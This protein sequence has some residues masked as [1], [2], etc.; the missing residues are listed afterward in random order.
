MAKSLNTGDALYATLSHLFCVDDDNVIKEL[1]AGLACTP[2]ANVLLPGTGSSTSPVGRSFRTGG[3]AGTSPV[4]YGVDFPN[5]V[6]SNAANLSFFV[7]VN[8][9]N[10]ANNGGNPADGAPMF[11]ND[12]AGLRVGEGMQLDPATGKVFH[13]NING[14]AGLAGTLNTAGSITA[15]GVKSFGFTR[16]AAGV[17]KI[18][19]NGVVDS[20]YT[21]GVA[22][23]ASQFGAAWGTAEMSLIGGMANYG[24]VSFDYAYVCDWLGTILTDADVLRLHNSLA[25]GDAFDLITLPAPTSPTVTTQPANSSV[26]EGATATFTAAFANTPTS[27]AWEV[28]TDSGAT[29]G[30]V[31]GGSGATTTAY[32]T[33]ATTLAMSGRRFR[34]TAT[35]AGGSVTTNG[36]AT[37]TVTAAAS[38]APAITSQP[39]NQTA[40]A[41]G[42]ATFT[43]TATGSGALT[44]QW[45][46]NGVNV[47]VAV[48]ITASVPF[49]YTTPAL[50]TG[51][52]GALYSVVVTGD[53]G[54][55]ATSANATLTVNPAAATALN[56]TIAAAA[57]LTGIR[58]VVLN[59]A[60]PGVGATVIKAFAD[61]VFDGAGAMSIDITSL[62]VLQGQYRWVE[63]T[64][65]NGD[66]AQSPAP[67]GAHGPVVAS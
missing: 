19:I 66:P 50:V 14:R 16:T 54:P 25:G 4:V 63:L 32:T 3:G 27:W 44:A 29:W 60:M 58:G 48:S 9:Y 57:G 2:H 39:G 10:S 36:A 62:G 52:S 51:D 18:Y 41:G 6:A 59:A 13:N 40:T 33:A 42:T 35:N 37:L 55:P 46:K 64:Q 31:S 15:G 53:T 23:T 30:A 28:S 56:L 61:E 1:K 34:C 17:V 45:R 20:A 21:G 8:Q 38:T 12:A 22:N 26:T 11:S 47:G 65:S 67:F 43:A 24:W 5:Y 7:A 49:S